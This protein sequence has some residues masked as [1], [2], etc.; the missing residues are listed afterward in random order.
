MSCLEKEVNQESSCENC[1]ANVLVFK[2]VDTTEAFCSWLFSGINKGG[3]ELCHNFKRYD[4]IPILQYLY[5][6]GVKPTIIPNGGK[7]MS[8]EVPRCKIRMIDSL[9]FLPTAL[10]K[11][12]KMFGFTELHKGIFPHLY[13]KK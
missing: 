4:S 6:N 12:P 10:S 3:T 8:I 9:N 1:G 7:N 5:G 13:Y 2:G 11:L